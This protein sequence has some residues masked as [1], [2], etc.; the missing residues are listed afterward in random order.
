MQHRERGSVPLQVRT[1]GKSSILFR[2]TPENRASCAKNLKFIW[3]RT[4]FLSWQPVLRAIRPEEGPGDFI[5]VN[6]SD[7]DVIADGREETVGDEELRRLNL[8]RQCH[9]TIDDRLKEILVM[10]DGDNPEEHRQ[11]AVNGS[12]SWSLAEPMLFPHSREGS[13]KDD[14]GRPIIPPGAQ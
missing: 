1:E 12:A 13:R 4:V 8:S 9:Y 11:Q 2:T 6:T 10:D 5:D 3:I 7:E 14:H